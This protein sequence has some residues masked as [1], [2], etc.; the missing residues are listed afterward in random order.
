MTQPQLINF[1]KMRL[2]NDMIITRT[3]DQAKCLM[4]IQRQIESLN[5][6]VQ[7][8][9]A[10]SFN[11]DDVKTLADTLIQE[12]NLSFSANQQLLLNYQKAVSENEA[13]ELD[14]NLYLFLCKSGGEKFFEVVRE[15]WGENGWMFQEI[16]KKFNIDMG[17]MGS[18]HQ[19]SSHRTKGD[20]IMMV[21]ATQGK[22]VMS[23]YL[24][25]FSLLYRYTFLTKENACL[26]QSIKVQKNSMTIVVQKK[27]EGVEEYLKSFEAIGTYM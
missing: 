6:L 26:Y 17:G 9:K 20:K 24:T 2:D 7:D 12:L 4:N 22:F 25:N 1:G 15:G 3:E 5:A 27:T 8:M 19:L 14:Q 16:P 18:G 21:S 10:K 11:V 23:V 13:I